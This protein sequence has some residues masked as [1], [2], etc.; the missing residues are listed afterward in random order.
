MESKQEEVDE[1][2]GSDQAQVILDHSKTDDN[3]NEHY[4]ASHQFHLLQ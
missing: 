4:K 3:D 1:N 2:Q